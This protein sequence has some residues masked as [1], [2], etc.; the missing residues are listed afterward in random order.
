MGRVSRGLAGTALVMAAT[1]ALLWYGIKG[2][3]SQL[4]GRSVFRG[5][6]RRRSV[7]LTFDDGPSE[8]TAELLRYLAG[9]G[10]R[11]SF[12]QCGA[13]A[14]RLPA[15]ARAVSEAGHEIGNHTWSHPRLCPRLSRSPNFLS[16]ARIFGELERTQGLLEQ[17]HGE[18]PRLFRAPYGLRWIGLAAA[19][20]RLGLLGVMWTAIGH[21]WE[22][23]AEKIAA[24]VL[25]RIEPG[26]IVCLHDGRDVRSGVD[27][28]EM[29]S[30]LRLIVPSLK[31]G[32]YTFETVS[33]LLLPD[34]AL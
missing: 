29:L 7:A 23:R 12:F 1:T 8:G 18:P 16:R 25:A 21:D 32:G 19:Q 24:F 14:Q 22:W 6:G 31:N 20:R 30:A 4:L 27:L 26:A 13:N 15:E 11:A 10:I 5:A 33:E 34:P 2:R 9:E 17:L 3:S 28:S